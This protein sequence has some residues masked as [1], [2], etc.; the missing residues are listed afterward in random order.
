MWEVMFQSAKEF[1]KHF[2][3][4]DATFENKH[5][6]SYDNKSE[7]DSDKLNFFLFF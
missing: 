4:Y 7:E 5:N 2:K 6:K 1:L 3:Y